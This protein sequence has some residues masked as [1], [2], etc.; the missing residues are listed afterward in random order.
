MACVILQHSFD[1]SFGHSFYFRA[2]GTDRAPLGKHACQKNVDG[3]SPMAFHTPLALTHEIIPDPL[4][5][6]KT[7]KLIHDINSW[8]C[9]RRSPALR[10]GKQQP[11][12]IIAPIIRY[13][14]RAG[15]ARL[16]DLYII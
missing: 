9:P 3:R 15:I 6:L 5:K 11:H 13:E 14:H 4:V 12:R 16:I 8:I 10:A 7:A 2:A 1:W